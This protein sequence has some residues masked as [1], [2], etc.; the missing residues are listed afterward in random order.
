M[1][2]LP[3]DF[4]VRLANTGTTLCQIWTLKLKNGD[5]HRL[6]DHDADV[7]FG[8]DTYAAQT[9][10]ELSAVRTTL[11]EGVA[12]AT[13]SI[14]ISEQSEITEDS[15]RRGILNDSEIE[16]Y[17]VDYIVPDA[18]SLP[19]LGGT[20]GRQT[21]T[22]KGKLDLDIDGAFAAA[23]RQIGENYSQTC[24]NQ[25]GDNRCRYPVETLRVA[26]TVTASGS[27]NH[28][29]TSVET[30]KAAHY[31][32]FGVVTFETGNNRNTSHDVTISDADGTIHMGLAPGFE[33][34]P[35][36]TGTI[37]PGCSKFREMC[38]TRWNNVLNIRAEPDA[39]TP[40]DI[41]VST[42]PAPVTPPPITNQQFYGSFP[43]A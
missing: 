18:G 6:T 38:A 11:N 28:T 1:K 29:F 36:D 26:F 10:F 7:I 34:M 14:T 16:I 23:N 39:P 3:E 41:A 17:T 9:G 5:L 13:V 33:I 21:F 27:G 24:R 43:G 2:A 20:V 35:G 32:D 12:S 15:A 30:V 4:K 25:F 8:G 40:D 31:W 37:I 22:D 19:V 42:P